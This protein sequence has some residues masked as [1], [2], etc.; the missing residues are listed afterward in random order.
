MGREIGFG[1]GLLGVGLASLVCLL[2]CS[3]SDGDAPDAM[4]GAGGTPMGTAGQAV[5]G[6]QAGTSAAGG[7]GGTVGGATSGAGMSGS[8]SGGMAPTY[9]WGPAMTPR[10]PDCMRGEFLTRDPGAHETTYLYQ[11]S[12]A[13]VAAIGVDAAFVYF[14]DGGN[15]MRV[16][17]EGTVET[18][19]PFDYAPVDQDQIAV[20]GGKLYW[21]RST[22]G[23][24]PV[25]ILMADVTAPDA[26]SVL[27]EGRPQLRNFVVDDEA[28]YWWEYDTR[29]VYRL[30]HTGGDP[31][32]LLTDAIP[33]GMMS[34]EGFLYFIDDGLERIPTSGGD[35]ETLDNDGFEALFG[36]DGADIYYSDGNFNTVRVF[37]VDTM[38][39][40]PLA[41][42]IYD[43][44]G[45]PR[46][47]D[48]I[49]YFTDGKTCSRLLT[50]NDGNGQWDYEVVVQ[51]FDRAQVHAV[52][53]TH[54]FLIGADGVY[55]VARQ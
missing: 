23:S 11:S 27:V 43:A 45:Q 12:G 34:H 26:P 40:W 51:G 52:T 41:S 10:V 21:A 49:A 38:S 53:A 18:L 1:T 37:H 39:G 28:S 9:D 20:L 31:V 54:V 13:E 35:V 48:G 2:S 5:T 7:A 16:S 22:K 55:K 3:S 50:S 47:L 36:A 44:P 14:V 42:F 17:F 6:G 25:D 4:A 46:G 32:E 15:L 29:I 24:E 8:A 19:G 30:L 33:N